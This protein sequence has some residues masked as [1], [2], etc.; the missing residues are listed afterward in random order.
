M[1]SASPRSLA[2]EALTH[3]FHFCAPA[4]GPA[5][6]TAPRPPANSCAVA[7][8]DSFSDQPVSLYGE[9]LRDQVEER[10]KFYE[11]GQAPR[12]NIDIME[13]VAKELKAG[14]DD[15]AMEDATTPLKKRKASEDAD[16]TPKKS[17]KKSKKEKKEKKSEKK[18][19]KKHKE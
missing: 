10:L 5:P 11:T 6:G 13:E 14:D 17:S 4:P 8:I 12:R 16:E 2:P 7:R 18:K 15:V 1:P 9:R 19:K 3:T